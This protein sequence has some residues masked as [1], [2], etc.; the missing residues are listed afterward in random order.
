MP[1]K[2]ITSFQNSRVKEIRKLRE[3]R[4]R[5]KTG[6]FVVDD[7]RDLERALRCG[8]EVEYL[9]FDASTSRDDTLIAQVEPNRIFDVTPD[10]LARVS[11][12]QNPSDVVAV[13]KQKLPRDVGILT[14]ANVN[15]VLGLVDLK[16]PGN[17]GALLRT[18]DATRFDAICLI[19]CALDLYNP[20]VIRSSTGACFLNNIFTLSSEQ[21]LE[22][23]RSHAFSIIAAAVD[24]DVALHHADLTGRI[25]ILLGTEDIGLPEFWI[26]QADQRVRI[27]MNG[28]IVDSLNVSVSGAMFMYEAQRQITQP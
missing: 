21:A 5:Q 13:L 2:Q 3:H 26:N 12:R 17:I 8:Y 1:Y 9:F 22:V 15:R 28:D 6:S 11:Y 23:F 10:I 7:S 20:N 27:P 14:E 19:D 24:G 25:A 4:T 18:A 16:K